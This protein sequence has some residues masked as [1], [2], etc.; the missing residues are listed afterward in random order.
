MKRLKPI[1]L[2]AERE[3]R[4]LAADNE[5]FERGEAFS[6]EAYVFD[7]DGI[8]ILEDGTVCVVLS[9]ETLKGFQ[10]SRKDARRLGVALLEAA[11]TK[12][13]T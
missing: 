9:P 1:N 2:A 13:G 5:A 6:F 7:D 4:Q 10:L 12:V 11:N 3:K 8:G